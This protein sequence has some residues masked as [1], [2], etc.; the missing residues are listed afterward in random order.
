MIANI[1][2]RLF[3]LQGVVT[4]VVAVGAAFTLPDEP[5]S[6]RWL[7]PE[8]RQLAYDRIARDTVG[9]KEKSSTFSGLKEAMSDYRVW[10]FAFMQHM[11]LAANGFKNFFPTVVEYVST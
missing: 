10:A 7:T 5:L 9:K 8:E 3:I 4:F 6:T 1:G 11:H 2:T